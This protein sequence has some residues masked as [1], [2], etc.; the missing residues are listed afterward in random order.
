MW[1]LLSS[2]LCQQLHASQALALAS[3]LEHKTAVQET[4][5]MNAALVLVSKEAIA[6]EK[7]VK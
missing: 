4:V 2:L 3:A 5:H 7:T 6:W 1:L